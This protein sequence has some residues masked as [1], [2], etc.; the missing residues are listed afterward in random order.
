VAKE[1]REIH[2]ELLLGKRLFDRKG[3]AVG[4]IQEIDVAERGREPRTVEFLVGGY[5][6]AE[7]LSASRLLRSAIGLLPWRGIAHLYCVPADRLDFSD[8]NAPRVT[9]LREELKSTPLGS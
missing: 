2:V 7:R 1:I 8:P 9:C 3:R 5:G 6:L 4:R